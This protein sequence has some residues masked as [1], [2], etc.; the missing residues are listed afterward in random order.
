M[1]K[2]IKKEYMIIGAAYSVDARDF[3]VAIWDG[4]EF[5]GLNPGFHDNYMSSELHFDDESGQGTAVALECISDTST[6]ICD[7]EGV[8]VRL[9]NILKNSGIFTINGLKVANDH[10]RKSGHSWMILKN[11]GRKSLIDLEESARKF[12]IEIYRD[13]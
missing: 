12:G 6:K 9:N 10:M 3:R 11:M 1:R 2:Y 7:M 8:T 5:H 4:K 13:Y